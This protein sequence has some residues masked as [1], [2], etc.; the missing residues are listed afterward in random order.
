MGNVELW[1]SFS[2]RRVRRERLHANAPAMSER[3][4]EEEGVCIK[5]TASRRVSAPSS[6]SE[7]M[8]NSNHSYP[9][10]RQIACNIRPGYKV[11][12]SL[13]AN[14]LLRW[15]RAI[16]STVTV[17]E[18]IS[19]CRG[20]FSLSPRVVACTAEEI[21]KRS[22]Y[23]GEARLRMKG[24]RNGRLKRKVREKHRRGAE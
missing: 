9:Q 3:E 18:C 2:W 5:G 23:D 21:A 4:R 6:K 22:K 1:C 8:G 13:Y 12:A 7:T 20:C 17:E 14:P 19:S 10:T 24:K 11:S 15:E 16:F